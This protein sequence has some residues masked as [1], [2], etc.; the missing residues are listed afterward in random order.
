M[1]NRPPVAPSDKPTPQIDAVLKAE[2]SAKDFFTV[3]ADELK[4]RNESRHPQHWK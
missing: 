4:R 3:N 2:K 1:N